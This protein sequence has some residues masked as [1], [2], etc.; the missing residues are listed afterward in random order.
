M[1][2]NDN[3]VKNSWW[4]CIDSDFVGYGSQISN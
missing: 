1:S 4:N 2:K 3:V